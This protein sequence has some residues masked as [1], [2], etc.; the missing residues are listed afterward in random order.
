MLCGPER[1]PFFPRTDYMSAVPSRVVASISVALAIA[2]V[3]AGI[4]SGLSPTGTAGTMPSSDS[5]RRATAAPASTHTDLATAESAAARART[6]RDS[7]A[8]IAYGDTAVPLAAAAP[9]APAPTVDP[10]DAIA[11]NLSLK[12]TWMK[13]GFGA[14]MTATFRI[15]NGGDISVKDPEI[16]CVGYAKSGTAIDQN[17]RTVYVNVPAHETTIVRGFNMGFINDQVSA[18]DCAVT[19]FVRE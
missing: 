6:E 5:S 11:R 15:K 3:V 16:T 12:F 9:S 13:S 14:V 18:A 19:D 1:A 7:L 2:L 10:R 4:V 17:V 8:R